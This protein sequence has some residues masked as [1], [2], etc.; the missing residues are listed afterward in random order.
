MLSD[1]VKKKTEFEE[2]YFSSSIPAIDG[3]SEQTMSLSVHKI[4]KLVPLLDAINR[5]I[6]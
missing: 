6:Y 4:P 5:V 2:C 3:E 1:Q